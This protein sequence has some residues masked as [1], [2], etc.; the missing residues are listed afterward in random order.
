MPE[1]SS[2]SVPFVL[3]TKEDACSELPT[4]ALPALEYFNVP[5]PTMIWPYE[6]S[7]SWAVSSVR[8]PEPIL[9]R[10]VLK[11]LLKRWKRP[12]NVEDVPSKPTWRLGD[13]MLLKMSPEPASEP[14]VVLAL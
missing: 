13:A 1:L 9:V 7:P 5:P 8:T 11:A 6:P 3:A 14:Q 4:K 10:V 2:W 12:E